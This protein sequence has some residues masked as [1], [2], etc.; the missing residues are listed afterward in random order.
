[1]RPD[2][3]LK[4]T[5][6][7]IQNGLIAVSDRGGGE[8]PVVDATAGNVWSTQ[9]CIL[10]ICLHEVDGE[11][12]ITLAPAG[13]INSSYD[14]VFDGMLETPNQ[15]IVISTVEYEA[16]LQTSVPDRLTRVRIWLSHPKWPKQVIVG[17]G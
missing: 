6:R 10:V 11:A 7:P 5:K 8:P 9:S 15:Q 16:L 12:E 4:K 17:W 14:M 2:P 1:M 3:S 13:E